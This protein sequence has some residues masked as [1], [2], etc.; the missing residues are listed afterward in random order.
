MWLP[1]E[2]REKCRHAGR[3]ICTFLVTCFCGLDVLTVDFISEDLTILQKN[4]LSVFLALKYSEV[5]NSS[6]CT[7]LPLLRLRVNSVQV[8]DSISN[9]LNS[10]HHLAVHHCTMDPPS[11]EMYVFSTV[12]DFK[13]SFE[14][15]LFTVIF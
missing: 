13:I 11:Q 4:V 9:L 10:D 5:I 6:I 3:D 15:Y 8:C 14:L 12:G 1:L 2:K 7:Y